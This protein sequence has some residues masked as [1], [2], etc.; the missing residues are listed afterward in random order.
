MIIAIDPGLQGAIAHLYDDGRFCCVESMPVVDGEVSEALLVGELRA[1][2]D[3]TRDEGLGDPLVVVEQVQAFPK[4]GRSSC[5]NFG[6]SFGIVRGVV[7]GLGLS[8]ELVHPSVWKKAMK[9]GRDKETA[10]AKALQLFPEASEALKRKRDEGR[11][12]ALLLALWFTRRL[13]VQHDP[14]NATAA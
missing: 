4:Q 2:R 8:L 1:M 3:S 10:R 14:S 6:T 12:E 5:F 13:Q 9:L 7:A 11:A